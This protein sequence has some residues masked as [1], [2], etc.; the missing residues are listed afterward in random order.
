MSDVEFRDAIWLRFSLPAPTGDVDCSPGRQENPRGLHRL[1][2]KAATDARLRRHDA[3]AKVVAKAALAADPR[4]FKVAREVGLPTVDSRAWA[5]DVAL[6]LGFGRTLLDVT[7]VN[8]FS[9][10]RSTASRLAGSPAVAV[11]TAYDKTAKYS[12]LL[13]RDARP[14]VCSAR[15]HGAWGLGRALQALALRYFRGVRG[16]GRRVDG[17]GVQLADDEALR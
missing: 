12:A 9:A 13:K 3:L 7:V 8:S 14:V 6:D 2:C 16:S 1:G 11:E 10:A 5:G 15:G 4:A 17:Y